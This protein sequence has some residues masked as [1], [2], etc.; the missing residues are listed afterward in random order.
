MTID[1]ASRN[2][3]WG[4]KHKGEHNVLYR[5]EIKEPNSCNVSSDKYWIGMFTVNFTCKNFTW[6]VIILCLYDHYS[7]NWQLRKM[8]MSNF[9]N[10]RSFVTQLMYL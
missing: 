3:T 7:E 6:E 8:S 2:S 10:K 5:L 1:L 9:L 4:T